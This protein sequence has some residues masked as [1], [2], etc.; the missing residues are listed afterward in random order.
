MNTSTQSN[1]TIRIEAEKYLAGNQGETYYDSSSINYGKTYRQDGVDIEKTTDIGGGYNVGWIDS[2]EWLTYNFNAPVEGT[3]RIVARV[4]SENDNNHSF[5][6]SLDGKEL[7]RLNFNSTGGWQSWK[8]IKGKEIYLNEGNHQLK[9]DMYGSSFN[10]NHIKLVPVTSN[11]TEGEKN[12][13][14]QAEDYRSYSDSTSENI[15]QA[16]RTE[17]V[18]IEKTTDVGGGHNVGWIDSGEWLTYD[19]NVPKEGV[20]KLVTRIASNFDNDHK[21]KFSLD[22][23]SVDEAKF[24]STGGWQSWQDVAGKEINLS[25][26]NHQLK[27]D[28][29]GS[30]FNLNYLD[31]KY[32]SPIPEGQPSEPVPQPEPAKPTL[33]GADYYLAP[34]GNDS[35]D[36]SL[37]NPFFSLEKVASVAKPGDVIYLRGGEYNYTKPQWIGA[38]G[39]VDARITFMSAPG[40]TA[41]LDGSYIDDSISVKDIVGVTGKY[42]DFKN[43][44]VRDSKRHGI[45]GWG[46]SHVRLLDNYLHHNQH[47]GAWFGYHDMTTSTDLVFKGNLV[48]FNDLVSQY[49]APHGHPGALVTMGAANSTFVDNIVRKNYGEGIISV[50]TKGA[51][52]ANNQISD[53]LSV[54]LYLDNTSDVVAEKNLIYN[55]GDTRFHVPGR[56]ASGIQVAN[57]IYDFY[58][59]LSNQEGG[60]KIV[61]NIIANNGYGFFYGNYHNGGGLKDTLIANNTF[62]HSD[63]S[64]L[65]ISQDSGH[66]NTTFANNIFAQ[67]SGKKLTSFDGSSGINW[68]NNGWVG[69]DPGA[70]KGANDVIVDNPLLINP[71]IGDVSGFGLK[72]NSPFAGKGLTDLGINDDYFGT[73]RNGSVDLGAIQ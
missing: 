48:E 34:Y 47:S 62:Y 42:L 55:T 35:N 12:M 30:G 46:A 26:G 11:Q 31:F 23:K 29:V 33:E 2:G 41:I 65:Y 25:Q 7:D 17:G 73:A 72:D 61:N 67:E 28:F 66:S 69:G 22:G 63:D 44:E 32:V 45:S 13:R 71:S 21:I 51:Y 20:Y 53:N 15:G 6:V 18:D 37:E 40:E 49:D 56:A 64:L 5:G 39:T 16:Y 36:G 4:A 1:K 68:K 10:L 58:N 60:F 8:N 70:A 43:L 57:E 24:N 50:L 14:I 9:L 27:L 19:L 59:N 54:N 38:Q 3:Y 52:I